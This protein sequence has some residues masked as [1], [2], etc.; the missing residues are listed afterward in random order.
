MHITPTEIPSRNCFMR[1]DK[2]L[3]NLNTSRNTE[4][5]CT[6]L[7]CNWFSLQ[8]FKEH[9]KIRFN[10][11]CKKHIILRNIYRIILC[12][13]H[14]LLYLLFWSSLLINSPFSFKLTRVI[15]TLSISVHLYFVKHSCYLFKYCCIRLILQCL[16]DLKKCFPT[17]TFTSTY[18][19][20][21]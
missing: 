13:V 1:T 15:T 20:N 5:Y 18:S 11:S 4:L 19:G 6:V 17:I 7:Y 8:T 10:R 21:I 2:Y 12:L 9:V 14:I 3:K 16:C